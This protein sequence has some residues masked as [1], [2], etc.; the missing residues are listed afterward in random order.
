MGSWDSTHLGSKERPCTICFI[1]Y[2]R[3]K[4]AEEFIHQLL[5]AIG[6]CVGMLATNTQDDSA[7]GVQ[8]SHQAEAQDL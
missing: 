5:S 1:F 7:P 8:E 6:G 3:G 2:Q 4:E